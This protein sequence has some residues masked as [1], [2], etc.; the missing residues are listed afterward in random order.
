[1]MRN[2]VRETHPLRYPERI[3]SYGGIGKLVKDAMDCI[4]APIFS[5]QSEEVTPER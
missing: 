2:E 3:Q 5:L 1:M 4:N